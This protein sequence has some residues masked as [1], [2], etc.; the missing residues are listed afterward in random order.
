MVVNP[1]P[2]VKSLQPWGNH[3]QFNDKV[4]GP[5]R[6]SREIMHSSRP[7]LARSRDH[8]GIM[9]SSSAWHRGKCMNDRLEASVVG[10]QTYISDQLHGCS[11]SDMPSWAEGPSLGKTSSLMTNRKDRRPGSV[12]ESRRPENSGKTPTPSLHIDEY[13]WYPSQSARARRDGTQAVGNKNIDVPKVLT[14]EGLSFD[15]QNELDSLEPCD[16]DGSSWA[17]GCSNANVRSIGLVG[18]EVRRGEG[19]RCLADVYGVPQA[20]LAEAS[21]VRRH[22]SHRSYILSSQLAGR[23]SLQSI[24][25]YKLSSP[26]RYTVEST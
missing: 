6:E 3:E 24:T 12:R 19:N 13:P 10:S 15:P 2:R 8:I 5:S 7:S 23:K 4:P 21:E 26:L 11:I 14:P 22:C 20:I 17:H 25:L 1:N 9:N 18:R 16:K